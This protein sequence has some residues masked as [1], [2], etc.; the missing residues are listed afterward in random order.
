MTDYFT[1]LLCEKESCYVSRWCNKC[2]RLK[3]TIA[4]YGD[5][6]YE[7]VDKVFVRDKAQQNYKIAGELKKEIEQKKKTLDKSKSSASV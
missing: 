6:V 7:A 1:C 3:R 5:D 2:Q 4:L